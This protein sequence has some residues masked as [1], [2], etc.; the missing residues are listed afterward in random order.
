MAEEVGLILGM[1]LSNCH[2]KT[3]LCNQTV[4]G[5]NGS[6]GKT[7]VL[8][9]CWHGSRAECPHARRVCCCLFSVAAADRT[10]L[11]SRARV[12]PLAW[13]I[14][15]PLRLRLQV[16]IDGT[17][18]PLVHRRHEHGLVPRQCARYDNAQI[19]FPSLMF[20]YGVS[21]QMKKR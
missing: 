17:A 8:G 4:G 16:Q 5:E 18:R 14:S 6:C 9:D 19:T 10:L 12:F 2:P 1:M 13:L 11:F 7:V 21:V 3:L 20:Q 15:P